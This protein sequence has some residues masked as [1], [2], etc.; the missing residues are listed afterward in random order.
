[1]GHW[2]YSVIGVILQLVGELRAEAADLN[3]DERFLDAAAG[4]RSAT[5]A[6]V[7][8]GC[9]VSSTNYVATL[10]ERGA[11][12]ARADSLD[13]TFEVAD[14]E[15]AFRG[16]ELRCRTVD[17]S[18]NV[19]A[20][21]E[22]SGVRACASLPP[23]WP[24][25]FSQL[26]ARGLHPSGVQGARAPTAAAGG[27]AAPIAVG[28]RNASAFAV[29]RMSGSDCCNATPIR[30]LMPLS[31]ARHRRLPHLV[32]TAAQKSSARCRLITRR[33]RSR[34]SPI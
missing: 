16:R 30:S 19:L 32:R 13:I 7:C 11:A 17:V 15:A 29:R 10:L 21:P 27:R 8:R 34:I 33:R 24:N 6:A 25:W 23:G 1:M 3:S 9:K 2:D 14:A 31:C 20:R 26:D 22:D 28:C 4:N 12:R 18:R 5:L